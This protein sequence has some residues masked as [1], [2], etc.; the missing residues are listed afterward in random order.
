[1]ITFGVTAFLLA[2]AYR[3]WPLTHDDVVDDDVEDR[4]IASKR[5]RDSDVADVEAAEA[6]HATDSAGDDDS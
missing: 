6:A 2:M 1:M 3:S 4:L 5:R